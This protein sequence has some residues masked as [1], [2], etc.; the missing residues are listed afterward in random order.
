MA[1]I[2]DNSQRRQVADQ[3]QALRDC[4]ALEGELVDLRNAYEQYF[5]GTERLPPASAHQELKK[6]LDRLRM[7]F[8]R[9]TAVN[10][11]IQ[12]LYTKFT[13]YERLWNRTL[14]EMENGTY[15]RDL[16]KARLRAK[17]TVAKTTLPLAKPAAPPANQPPGP[18]Q[19]PVTSQGEL[20][21]GKIKAIY[22]AYVTAKKRCNE[23]TAG[24]NLE[25]LA[26]TL[27]KQV[28]ELLKQHNAK[29]VDFKVLIKEGKAVLKPVPRE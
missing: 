24:L 18:A 19:P 3:G 28:P 4:D 22:D 20:S 1:E 6:K 2:S 26:A 7:S 15:R 21:E 27:K 13:T 29:S 23:D 25:G 8:V 12:G 9:N 11:K 16:F 14:Q 5:L 10:F 17:P